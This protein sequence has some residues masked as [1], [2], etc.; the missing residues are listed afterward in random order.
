MCV[1]VLRNGFE[2]TCAGNIVSCFQLLSSFSSAVCYRRAHV[3]QISNGELASTRT[4]L[5]CPCVRYRLG[6]SGRNLICGL[7]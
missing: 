2:S 6:K 3:N 4:M 5:E 1:S 7:F